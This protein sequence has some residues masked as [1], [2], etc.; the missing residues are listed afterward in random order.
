M[1]REE[2]GVEVCPMDRC[3]F[4]VVAICNLLAANQPSMG[5][6]SLT[7]GSISVTMRLKTV[8]DSMTVTPAK[9][10]GEG[11]DDGNSLLQVDLC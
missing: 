11:G 6:V 2:L 1:D 5:W 7:R 3:S 8:R 4:R 9:R 10:R